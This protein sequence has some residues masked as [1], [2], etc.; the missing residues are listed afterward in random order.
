MPQD[1]KNLQINSKVIFYVQNNNFS[2]TQ[3]SL[4]FVSQKSSYYV[5]DDTKVFFLFLLRKD[6][7]VFRVLLFEVFVDKHELKIQ[8][9]NYLKIALIV[10]NVISFSKSILFMLLSL[11]SLLKKES[12]HTLMVFS[13]G[14]FV[15]RD[16]ASRLPMK[17][18]GS[19]SSISFANSKLFLQYAYW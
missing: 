19:W 15:K 13:K 16:L 17:S 4:A 3:L 18:P 7:D 8:V 1:P 14:M 5:Y 2:Y 11:A 6:F 12:Q 9:E 10:L